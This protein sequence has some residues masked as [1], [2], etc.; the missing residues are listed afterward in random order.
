MLFTFIDFAQLAQRAPATGLLLVDTGIEAISVWVFTLVDSESNGNET[1]EW[2]QPQPDPRTSSN[3][4]CG[5]VG[6][7]RV[8]PG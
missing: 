2:T 6:R 4:R 7:R 3:R 1:N 5:C 8:G